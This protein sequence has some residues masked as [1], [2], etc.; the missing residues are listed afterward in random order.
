MS[1]LRMKYYSLAIVKL[2]K[3]FNQHPPEKKLLVMKRILRKP[4][5]EVQSKRL[6]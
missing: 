4:D 2:S 3:L 5:V 6:F 1:N